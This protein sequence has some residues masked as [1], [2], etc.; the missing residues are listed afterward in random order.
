MSYTFREPVNQIQRNVCIYVYFCI[1]ECVTSQILGSLDQ[2]TTNYVEANKY[3]KSHLL[4]Y[5]HIDL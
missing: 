5:S 4:I 1:L 2:T 3:H